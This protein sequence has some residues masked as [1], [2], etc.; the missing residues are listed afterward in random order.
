MNEEYIQKVNILNKSLKSNF[1]GKIAELQISVIEISLTSKTATSSTLRL[2]K[3]IITEVSR[4]INTLS[5]VK[6]LDIEISLV[7]KIIA[8]LELIKERCTQS[9]EQIEAFAAKPTPA[10]IVRLKGKLTEKLSQIKNIIAWINKKEYV[11]SLYYALEMEKKVSAEFDFLEP[12]SREIDLLFKLFTKDHSEGTKRK[13]LQK[14]NLYLAKMVELDEMLG[15]ESIAHLG[16]WQNL[17]D[18]FKYLNKKRDG[19]LRDISKVK[20]IKDVLN[21]GA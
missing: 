17:G 8:E 7:S 16:T 21:A 9:L 1:E 5:N 11:Y 2:F 3:Q 20:K 14:A 13:L 19:Y 12:L 10:S 18:R 6:K 15:K 4:H